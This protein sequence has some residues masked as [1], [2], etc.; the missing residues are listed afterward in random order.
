MISMT[1][2]ARARKSSTDIIAPDLSVNCCS[3][4]LHEFLL[5]NRGDAELTFLHAGLV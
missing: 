1:G 2:A 4:S 3:A 5:S